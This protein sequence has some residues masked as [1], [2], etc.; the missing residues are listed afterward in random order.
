M[1]KINTGNRTKTEDE[2]ALAD[3]KTNI[4]HD[5]EVVVEGDATFI[6]TKSAFGV[7]IKTRIA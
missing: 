7:T 3:L 6:V 1:T 5:Q 4:A 2:K